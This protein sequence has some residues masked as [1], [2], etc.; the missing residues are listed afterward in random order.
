M[1]E[2]AVDSLRSSHRL[3]RRVE[4]LDH[5]MRALRDAMS[6][7]CKDFR[8]RLSRPPAHLAI[9]NIR[10]SVGVHW[11]ARA[12]T[13]NQSFF[14]LTDSERGIAL[15]RDMSDSMR[16]VFLSYELKRIELNAEYRLAYG[17]RRVL[18]EFSRLRAAA[19]A[20][21]NTN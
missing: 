11:R 20:W 8:V 3:R 6:T 14:R 10:G 9:R 1:S 17:E 5:T 13:G 2:P 15:L 7:L 18:D 16:S 4:S 19:A 21:R 12:Y